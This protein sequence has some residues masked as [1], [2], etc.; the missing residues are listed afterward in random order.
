MLC[1]KFVSNFDAGILCQLL[2]C[3][4]NH[5]SPVP[6]AAEA[7]AVDVRRAAYQFMKLDQYFAS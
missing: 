3:K 6:S 2:V 7:T 4:C 1:R 5:T